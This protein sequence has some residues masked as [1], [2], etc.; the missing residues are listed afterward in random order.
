MDV[1]RESELSQGGKVGFP[2]VGK[3][4]FLRVK[5]GVFI[6]LFRKLRFAQ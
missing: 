5:M 2:R 1:P 3:W 4:T 6:Y